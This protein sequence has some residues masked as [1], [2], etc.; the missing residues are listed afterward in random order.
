MRARFF[1]LKAQYRGLKK[2]AKALHAR[3]SALV[4]TNNGNCVSR[5]VAAEYLIC[6]LREK[7]KIRVS[8]K[9]SCTCAMF[10]PFAVAMTLSGVITLAYMG[11]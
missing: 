8:Q 2:F 7:D 5:A 9:S 4:N 1:K 6:Q 10:F 11:A 3:P